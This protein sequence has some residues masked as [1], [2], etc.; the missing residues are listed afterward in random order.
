MKMTLLKVSVLLG[1]CSAMTHSCVCKEPT[2]VDISGL[3]KFTPNHIFLDTAFAGAHGAVAQT[4]LENQWANRF[5]LDSLVG[6]C[7]AEISWQPES[8]LLDVAPPLTFHFRYDPVHLQ[9]PT[10]CQLAVALDGRPPGSIDNPTLR[11][12]YAAG[13]AAC[14]L[15]PPGSEIRFEA[16][17]M[18]YESQFTLT[19]V[20]ANPA[21]VAANQFRYEFGTPSGDCHLFPMH[22]KDSVG[23]I[24]PG[25]SESIEFRFVP[26]AEGAFECR[27]LF[28][29]IQVSEKPNP[30]SLTLS[31]PQEILFRGSAGP[32]LPLWSPCSSNVNRDW[33]AVFGL[34]GSEIYVAGSGGTIMASGGGCQWNTSGTVF[35]EVDLKG[36][37]GSGEEEEKVLWADGT[38]PPPQGSFVQSGAILRSASGL[39]NKLDEGDLDGYWSV[40]GSGPGDVYFGGVGVATDFPNAKHWDG[41]ALTGI[42]ISDLGMSKVSGLSGSGPNDVWAVLEQSFHSV[43]RFDGNS[44]ENQTQ[45]F[46]NQALHDVWVEAEGSNFYHLYTVGEGGSIYHFDPNA[47]GDPWTDESI[48]GETRTFYGVWVSSTGQVFVVGQGQVIYR[49]HVNEPGNWTLQTTPQDLPA[50]D[51]KDVWGASDDA[52]YAVGTNG[53]VIRYTPSG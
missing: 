39:W 7:P 11:I 41:T 3:I 15:D 1:L 16:V 30:P 32:P 52:V 5:P 38:I 28:S 18:G 46:M 34:S 6:D 13:E 29:S 45:T 31:C 36:I 19:V 50:G 44:W 49:G 20:N 42:Q 17:P 8:G 9:E 37:W 22:P 53:V 35:S 40:W 12:T 2:T 23:V 24:G 14:A 4:D 21:A 25:Q 43:Y 51:L 10:T 33:D 26:D 48:A 27:R 47:G